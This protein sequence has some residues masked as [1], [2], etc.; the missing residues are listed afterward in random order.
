MPL[1]KLGIGLFL[2]T[3][4]FAGLP[5]SWA[6]ENG[7]S[8]LIVPGVR[9]GAITPQITESDLIKVYGRANVKK[10]NIG[11]GEGETEPGTVI[12]PKEPVKTVGILWKDQRGRRFARAVRMTETG[13]KSVWRTSQGITLGTT[14]KELEGINGK[15]FRLAG[16]AWDYSGTV[17]SWKQGK[18]EKELESQGRVVLRLMPNNKVAEREYESVLGEQAFRSDHPV[19]QKINP[20]VYEII[21]VFK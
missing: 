8:W 13:H 16:F 14:L 4:V 12:F 7:N 19:M 1:I 9:V 3:S 21:V 10:G 17:L 20:K 5:S 2:L 11:L 6:A 18:L 15:P